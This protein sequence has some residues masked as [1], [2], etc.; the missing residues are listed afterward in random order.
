MTGNPV[1]D[2]MFHVIV[3][4]GIGLVSVGGTA[5]GQVAPGRA[6]AAAED[7]DAPV[8]MRDAGPGSDAFPEE[9]ASLPHLR[10]SDAGDEEDAFPDETDSVLRDAGHPV[11]ATSQDAFP[12]E[13]P[14]LV[15]DAHAPMPDASPPV[16]DADCFPE[17]TAI[18]LDADCPRIHR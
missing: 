14:A 6:G 17:E 8:T 4:G 5:C 1:R 9:D 15:G 2:R 12:M 13:G 16:E 7:A 11:D 3:L 10:P 18:Q